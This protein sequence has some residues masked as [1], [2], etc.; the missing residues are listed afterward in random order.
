MGP[1]SAGTMVYKLLFWSHRS[2]DFDVGGS[3]KRED[4]CLMKARVERIFL[5]LGGVMAVLAHRTAAASVN[6]T[7]FY[8]AYQPDVPEDL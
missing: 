4:V 8:T 3:N 5:W 6:S 1:S 7:C 2:I